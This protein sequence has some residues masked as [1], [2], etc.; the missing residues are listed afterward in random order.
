MAGS[1]GLVANTLAL[2]KVAGVGGLQ[3]LKAQP[4]LA[5]AIPTTGAIF[6][7]GLGTVVGNNIVGKALITTGDG[8]AIP[9]K[10]LEIMW[11]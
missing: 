6:F 3:I 2:A 1:A 4:Y 7:Y 9:M 11:N 10:A 5:I 8:L